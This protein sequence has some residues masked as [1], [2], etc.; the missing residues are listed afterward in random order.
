[1]PVQIDEDTLK[2]IANRTQGKYFRATDYK[3][4]RRIYNAIDKLERTKLDQVQFRQYHEYYLLTLALALLLISLAV[5][6][7][8]TYFRRTP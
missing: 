8:A 4:L 6:A 2:E 5:I 1:M 3:S 7:D